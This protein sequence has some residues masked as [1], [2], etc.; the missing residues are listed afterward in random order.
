VTVALDVRDA[1]A[2]FIEKAAPSH[3]SLIDEHHQMDAL[4]G[5]VNV[6]SGIWIN[7]QGMVVRPPEPAWPGKSMFR[8]MMK[9]APPL[10]D[11]VDPYI[12]KSLEQ[13][14]QIK[15]APDRY[16]AAVRDWVANGEASKFALTPD[17]VLD[18]SKPRSMDASAAAAH[19]ELGQWLRAQ[20]HD[21]DAVEHF[22][23]AHDLQP[24][25]WT[26]KR[27]AWQYVNPLLQNARDVYGTSWA[28]EVE[29]AGAEN[30][31]EVASDL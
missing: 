9:G 19:F 16:L 7:E 30:Y 25:N 13:T 28:D 14:A 26:Y 12:R 21:D 5:V 31:Y 17:Q 27:Q 18:R 11:D 1:A 4:F 20:G 29:R 15:V 23:R 2:P 8:E 3:P 10:P 22:K 6:P 24:E